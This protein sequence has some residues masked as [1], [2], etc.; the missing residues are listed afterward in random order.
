MVTVSARKN[1]FEISNHENGYVILA[2]NNDSHT[3]H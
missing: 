3:T 1:V 2:S